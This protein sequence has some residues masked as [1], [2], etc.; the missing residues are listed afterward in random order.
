MEVAREAA[1]QLYE[2]MMG[3]DGFYKLWKKQNPGANAKQLEERFIN[4]NWGKCLDFARA[5]LTEMLKRPDV[6]EEMKDE[7]M[8]ILEQDYTLRH[9]SVGSPP[10]RGH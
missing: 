6:S 10:F 5:T 3:N 1:G 9:R 8:V 2:S 4:K 7:I